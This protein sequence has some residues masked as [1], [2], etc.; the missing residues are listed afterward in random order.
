M[1]KEF[2]RVEPADEPDSKTGQLNDRNE[3]AKDGKSRVEMRRKRIRKKVWRK[4]ERIRKK[5]VTKWPTCKLTSSGS[6]WMTGQKVRPSNR[7]NDRWKEVGRK[8]GS[9]RKERKSGRRKERNLD[10]DPYLEHFELGS[11]QERWQ[12]EW[13]RFSLK[14][15]PSWVRKSQRLRVIT[16]E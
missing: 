12:R 9:R 14:E 13:T 2:I 15:S 3:G 11:R 4:R 8:K 16:I 10:L 1:E 7:L 6:E 5:E